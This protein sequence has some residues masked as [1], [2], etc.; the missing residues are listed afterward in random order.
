MAN[1]VLMLSSCLKNTKIW[2]AICDWCAIVSFTMTSHCC[3][4][5]ESMCRNE[6]GE[7]SFELSIELS[8][9]LFGKST[10]ANCSLSAL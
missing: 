6:L 2:S 10:M 3:G 7:L 8:L 9:E 5:D 4:V 1:P